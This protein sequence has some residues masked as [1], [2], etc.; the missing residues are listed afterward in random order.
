M[1]EARGRGNGILASWD[2]RAGDASLVHAAQEVP[3]PMSEAPPPA[4]PAAGPT[5]LDTLHRQIHRT[6]LG[7]IAVSAVA[8][9]L[10]GFADSEPAL[11]QATTFAAIGLGLGCVVLRRL[12]T[13]PM[14][15]PRAEL[16]LGVAGLAA[17]AGLAL[18]GAFVAW[19]QDAA[20]TGLAYCGG[21]FILCA[22]P[23]IPSHLR[24]RRR[25]IDV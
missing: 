3:R 9:V 2:S 8:A 25:R 1:P 24:V 16:R 23:P 17:G 20:R 21:A 19:D 11:S 14:I 6:F 10:A 7:A 15:G 13:S 12:S 22:R 4:D 18:L 5:A